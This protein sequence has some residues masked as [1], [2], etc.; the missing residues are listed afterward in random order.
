MG[1]KKDPD[2]FM[3]YEQGDSRLQTAGGSLIG[4]LGLGALGLLAGPF[5]PIAVPALAGLGASVGGGIGS[6]FGPDPTAVYAEAEEEDPDFLD[7]S[8]IDAYASGA[9]H[10]PRW[11][12]DYSYAA[13]YGVQSPLGFG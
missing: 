12:Q 7:T 2:V 4:G 8:L 3:G 13:Q 5:A 1:F 11:D 6:T 10:D 9:F